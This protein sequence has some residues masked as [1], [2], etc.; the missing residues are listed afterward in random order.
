MSFKSDELNLVLED[1][2]IE[3]YE[4]VVSITEKS[5]NLKA[6]ISV[7]STTLGPAMG[8]TRIYPYTKFEDALF[9]VLRLSKGMTYKCAIAESGLGGGK[10]VIIAD[11]SKDKTPELLTAFG[12]AVDRLMGSYICAEDVGCSSDDAVNIRK[13]TKHVVGLNSEN[14]SGNPSPYTAWGTFRGIQAALNHTFGSDSLEGKAVAIQGLGSVGVLLAELLYWHG[15]SLIINDIDMEKAKRVAKRFGAKTATCEEILFTEC[16]VLAPCALGAVINK[17]TIPKLQCK[18][19]AGCAN[20]QLLD[21]AD[22]DT[23][24]KKR[25][26]YAPDFVI[27]AG[28]LVNVTEELEK[29]G[30][31]PDVARKKVDQIYTTMIQLFTL[32]KENDYSPL[33]AAMNL[34]EYRLK[35]AVGK[36]EDGPYF[37]HVSF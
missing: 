16:D 3:G 36:R 9:D 11:S 34:A 27:N 15:A 10:S 24:H 25:I 33:R 6:I 29:N 8:G 14:S 1:L 4:K 5:T 30:Y 12:V 31:Q 32:A 21:D 18:I 13:G 7:H 2:N 26:L 20:N 28:G 37:H 35:Y 23:L 17:D 22:A 19:I